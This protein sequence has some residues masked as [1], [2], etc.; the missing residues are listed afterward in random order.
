[1]PA[2]SWLTSTVSVVIPCFNAASFLEET[3]RS[4]LAQTHAPVEVIVVDD[5]STDGS[6]AVAAAF[7]PKV[8]VITQENRGESAARNVGMDHCRG[9]WIAFLDADDVWQPDKLE[10]QLAVAADDTIAVHTNYFHFGGDDRVYDVSTIPPDVRYRLETVARTIPIRLSS[11]MVRRALPVRFEE[12]ARYGEDLLYMLDLVQ[13]GPIAL[14]AEPLTGYRVHPGSQSQRP[15]AE[16]LWHRSIEEWLARRT[17]R[18]PPR[19]VDDIRRAGVAI[20]AWA[21]RAAKWERRWDE[22]WLLRRHLEAYEEWPEAR[23]V[24]EEWIPPLW[25][26]WLRDRLPRVRLPARHPKRALS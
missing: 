24:V 20:A 15:A 26:Y 3:L 12:W 4:V 18:L 22:Y 1:M 14:V 19:T 13:Q 5:G 17:D 25:L 23:A 9:D 7:G 16:I 2:P 10:R 6:A 8:H 11:L 21:A